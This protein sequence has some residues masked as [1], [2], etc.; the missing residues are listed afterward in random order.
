MDA[1]IPLLVFSSSSADSLV[2]GSTNLGKTWTRRG[3]V[4]I[5]P[6]DMSHNEHMMV[7][8]RDGRL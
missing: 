5:P 8:L 2:Y 6:A 3:G 1:R 4:A 7:E